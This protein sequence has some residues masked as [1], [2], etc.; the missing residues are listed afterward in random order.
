MA[1]KDT[2]KRL[3]DIIEKLEENKSIILVGSDPRTAECILQSEIKIAEIIVKGKRPIIN[4][5]QETAD[6]I[7]AALLTEI[8][9]SSGGKLSTKE[10]LKAYKEFKEKIHEDRE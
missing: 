4:I 1:E 7:I 5:N 9:A 6:G 2:L 3:E 8:L 10:I